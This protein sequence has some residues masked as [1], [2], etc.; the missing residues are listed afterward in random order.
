MMNTPI[1]APLAVVL[2]IVFCAFCTCT[3]WVLSAL[4]QLNAQG[5]AVAFLLGIMLLLPWMLMKLMAYTTSI[6]GDLPRYAR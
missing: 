6:I 1:K 5:Y 3:G 4:H 2:W